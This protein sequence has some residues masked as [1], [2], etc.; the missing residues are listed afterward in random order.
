MSDAESPN[1]FQLHIP[2][3]VEIDKN[4]ERIAFRSLGELLAIEDVA[5][6]SRRQNF[7]QFSIADAPAHPT[8]MAELDEGYYW[9]VIGYLDRDVAL[10]RWVA[11]TRKTP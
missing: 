7:H 11:R 10:P 3:F 2:T 4:S 8:L 6:W 5:F 1:H 9:W